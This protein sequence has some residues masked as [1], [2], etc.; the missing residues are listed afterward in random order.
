MALGKCFR[1]QETKLNIQGIVL[2][3]LSKYEGK[4]VISKVTLAEG[5]LASNRKENNESVP[6][7]SLS[8]FSV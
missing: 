8:H 1:L 4:T 3:S 5:Q 2:V 6:L 7:P